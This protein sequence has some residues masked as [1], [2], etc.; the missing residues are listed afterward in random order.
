MH[1]C[2]NEVYVVFCGTTYTTIYKIL[3]K[4]NYSVASG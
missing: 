3:F 2:H 4:C 1:I